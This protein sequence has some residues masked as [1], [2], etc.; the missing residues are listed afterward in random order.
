M[1]HLPY[2]DHACWLTFLHRSH[3]YSSQPV[4]FQSATQWRR[5]YICRGSIFFPCQFDFFYVFLPA[6]PLPF[7]CVPTSLY[8]QDLHLYPCK[9]SF[10]IMDEQSSIRRVYTTCQRVFS[11]SDPH[12][13]CSDCCVSSVLT[14]MTNH[15]SFICTSPRRHL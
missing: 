9:D 3:V 12:F 6:S 11:P 5:V 4:F 15:S 10:F 13:K 1:S 8:W 14:C 2:L 7:F